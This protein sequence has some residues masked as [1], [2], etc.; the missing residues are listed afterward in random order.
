MEILEVSLILLE[1]QIFELLQRKQEIF[2]VLDHLSDA[3]LGNVRLLVHA[4][5]TQSLIVLKSLIL[6]DC[7][8]IEE[9]VLLVGEHVDLVKKL[10]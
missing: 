6:L 10:L 8:L 4:G 2:I 5:I 7:T 9:V 1:Q 3:L